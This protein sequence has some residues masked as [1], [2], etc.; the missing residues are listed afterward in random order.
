MRNGR[1][2]DVR[3]LEFAPGAVDEEASKKVGSIVYYENHNYL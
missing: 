3:H 2:V 1:R